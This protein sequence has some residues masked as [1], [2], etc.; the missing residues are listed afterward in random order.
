VRITR[1]TLVQAATIV[2]CGAGLAFFGCLGGIAIGSLSGEN[3]A[4]FT[5]LGL[6]VAGLLVALYG[7][8]AVL[9]HTLRIV[10]RSFGRKESR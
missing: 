1:P 8:L 10:W 5:A 6:F 4:Y 3:G 7:A 2:A 9:V